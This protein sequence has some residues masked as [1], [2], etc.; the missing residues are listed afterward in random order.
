MGRLR[1]GNLTRN[2]TTNLEGNVKILFHDAPRPPMA[3]ASFNYLGRR[4]GD[5]A[6]H[7]RGLSAHILGPCVA[8]QMHDNTTIQRR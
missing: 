6:Q 7:I 4:A 2:R 1:F 5:K 3:R 8:C